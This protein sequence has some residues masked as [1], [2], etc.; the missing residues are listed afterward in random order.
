MARRRR[1]G[2][3]KGFTSKAQWRLF[4]VNPRLRK[5]AKRNAHQTMSLRGG[6]KVAYRSLPYR[7]G[8]PGARSVR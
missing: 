8:K 1:G 7:K 4:F 2:L 5:Y 3:P 6:K